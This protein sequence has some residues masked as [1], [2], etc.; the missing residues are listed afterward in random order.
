MKAP[1]SDPGLQELLALGAL[2]IFGCGLAL[3]QDD[4]V[5]T[6]IFAVE[7]GTVIAEALRRSR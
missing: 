1:W 6:A 2:A 7:S 3:A 5:F 4:V